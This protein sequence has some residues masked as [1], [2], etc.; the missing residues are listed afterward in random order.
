MENKIESV[1]FI[2]AGNVATHLAKALSK[3]ISIK[4]ITSKNKESAI[5]LSSKIGCK[6]I[7]SLDELPICDLVIICTNDESIASIENKIPLNYN[8]VYTSGSIEINSTSNRTKYGVFYPLQ[9]FS[10]ERELD[11]SNVPFLIE[12]TNP[13][14][15][16]QLFELASKLSTQ[17]SFTSS[18]E[19][20]RIHLSAVFV[21]NF[22]NHLAFLAK[23][24]MEENELNWDYL[25]P[26]IKETSDKII[27]TEPFDSQTGPAR[28][29]DQIIINEHLNLLN[30]NSKEIYKII[31]ESISKTYLNP[32][33]ND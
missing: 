8:V 21:N 16:N 4:G 9:T 2:G 7:E 15:S 17:V 26:L 12:S 11:I 1:V 5:L 25:K 27:S 30:D 24:F 20:K 14:F 3:I 13:E 33:K 31:S 6:F 29:N 22:S 10:K 23:E 28:R 32:G 19:R 18:I